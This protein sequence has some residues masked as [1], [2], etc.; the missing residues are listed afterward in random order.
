[1]IGL[2][3][4]VIGSRDYVYLFDIMC[5]CCRKSS[6]NYKSFCNIKF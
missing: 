5:T 1:M 3:G 6:F 4:I 2:I